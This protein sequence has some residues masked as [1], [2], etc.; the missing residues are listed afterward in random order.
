[1]A[2]GHSHSIRRFDSAAIEPER[3]VPLPAGHPALTEGRT[4][5]KATV[6][7]SKDSPRFLV[8][9]HNNPKLGKAVTKGPRKGW[10]I[11][12]LALEERATC[13]R[14]C[15]QW[16][17]CYGNSMPFSRRHTPDKDFERYLIAEIITL[18]RQHPEGLLIR[19][20]SLGDF[21]SPEY[22]YIWA[23]MLREFPQL[24]AFGYTA[25]RTDEGDEDSRRIA[26]AIKVL[27][28]GAWSRF[29][30][31]TSGGIEARSTTLVVDDAETGEA[32]G[33]VMCPAQTKATE[34]CATCGLC[35]ADNARDKPIGFLRH[36]RKLATGKRAERQA[37]EPVE[38]PAPVEARKIGSIYRPISFDAPPGPRAQQLLDFLKEETVRR[39]TA[40]EGAVC[41]SI[42]ELAKGSGV[43]AGSMGF[44][45][46]ELEKRG[47]LTVIPGS[48]K[49]A[50]EYRLAETQRAQPAPLPKAE[51]KIAVDEKADTV[52]SLGRLSNRRPASRS[53]TPASR[54]VFFASASRHR[55]DRAQVIGL[56]HRGM[57]AQNISQILG[58]SME[59]VRRVIAE[60]EAAA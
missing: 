25:H 20:H 14:S 55:V 39:G 13:P 16:D 51:P 10:P 37:K 47:L 48:P 23:A 17:S 32:A 8:S 27:T 24:H 19:L 42:K 1:M 9:G 57:G 36:G 26:R 54:A 58:V 34:A 29:A 40:A 4:I 31:R 2:S 60:H 28:D 43:P 56:R 21:Y 6:T 44:A 12:H 41:A 11:F 35:W 52:P 53:S 46:Y 15:L 5:F 3:V 59:D 30:I 33:A 45:V 38:A 50:S 49:R 22:V 18:A 7:A